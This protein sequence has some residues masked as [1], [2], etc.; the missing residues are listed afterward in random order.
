[1]LT[2]DDKVTI[3]CIVAAAICIC[4]L[5]I[6]VGATSYY[7]NKAAFNAGYE[8]ATLPG[9]SGSYWVKAK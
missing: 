7:T 2:S 1:M 5:F 6:V 4:C 3:T 9:Q 8:E